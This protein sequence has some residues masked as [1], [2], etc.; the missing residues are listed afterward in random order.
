MP[1]LCGFPERVHFA[2]YDKVVYNNKYISSSVS[3]FKVI[4]MYPN[5]L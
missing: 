2:F 3:E 1:K 5:L 4:E